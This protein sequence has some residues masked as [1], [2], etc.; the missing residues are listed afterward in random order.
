MDAVRLVRSGWSTRKVARHLGFNQSSIVRWVHKAPDDLRARIIPTLSSRPFHH[1]H[2]LSDEIIEKILFLRKKHHRCAQ[3]IHYQLKKE[4]VSVS[5]SSIK[6]TL[7][8]NDLTYPSKWKKWHQYPP[9]PIAGKPGI[10]TQIDTIFDG[11][12]DNRLYVYTLI[13]VFSRWAYALAVLKIDTHIKAFSSLNKPK[14]LLLFNFLPFNQT[15]V[16]SFLSGLLKEYWKVACP[17]DIQELECPLIT[18]I[19]KDLIEH[20]KMNASSVFL[21]A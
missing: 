17:T 16:L 15:M 2:E 6:R 21:K 4:G 13:D 20:C 8:R 11:P 9:R 7:K 3:V 14:I 10:L 19:W 12:T 1:P 5:L 18:D